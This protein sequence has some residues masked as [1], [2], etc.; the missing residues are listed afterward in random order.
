MS[1]N[2]NC[3]VKCRNM[4]YTQQ[5]SYLPAG[6]I[7]QLIELLEKM[8]PKKFTLIVHDSD[9][10]MQ[11]NHIDV[12]VHVMLSFKNARSINSIAKKL[13]DKPWFVK[14]WRGKAE[15]GYFYLIQTIK[16]SFIKHQYSPSKVI[17][18]FNYLEEINKIK[19][20]KTKERK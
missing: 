19:N 15:N 18:N 12:H 10:D 17:A 20:R 4:M 13:R 16:S 7:E 3:H 8:E 14:M 6:T 11:G 5:L 1:D 9:V 2:E